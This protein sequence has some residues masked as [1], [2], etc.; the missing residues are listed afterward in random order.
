MATRHTNRKN[1]Y[2][3]CQRCGADQPLSDMRWQNGI[4]VCNTYRC[5]DKAIIG[6]RDIAVSRAIEVYRHE[7]EVDPKLTS[8]IERKNDLMEVLY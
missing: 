5:I 7:L 3:T 8:P 1:V 6:S 4:L 2:H